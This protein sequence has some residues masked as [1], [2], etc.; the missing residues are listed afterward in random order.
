MRGHTMETP[1]HA[2]QIE[3]PEAKNRLTGTDLGNENG[4]DPMNATE[5]LDGENHERD[6][7]TGHRSPLLRS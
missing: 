6:D 5:T 3:T 7:G 4:V 1:H 2:L